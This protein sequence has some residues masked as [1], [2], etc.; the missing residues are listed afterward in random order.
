MTIQ[1]NLSKARK[2]S[3]HHIIT[4]SHH[5]LLPDTESYFSLING[6]FRCFEVYKSSTFPTYHNILF[7]RILPIIS[8]SKTTMNKGN[9]LF[10]YYF[11]LPNLVILYYFCT[12]YFAYFIV[13][14]IVDI[15][16]LYTLK[17]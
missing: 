3:H 14:Q 1:F 11:S 17:N 15:S 8:S 13:F 6:T 5:H 2:F 9:L 12:K 16:Q 7:F 10:C 4:S